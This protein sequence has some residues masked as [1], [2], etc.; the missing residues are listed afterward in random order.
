MFQNSP[1]WKIYESITKYIY[2]SF[3]K[4]CFESNNEPF[5]KYKQDIAHQLGM[6]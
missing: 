3:G 6:I 4:E 5:E 1:N 2:E